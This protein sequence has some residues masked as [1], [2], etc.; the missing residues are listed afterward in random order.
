M[1]DEVRRDDVQ[2]ALAAIGEPTRFRILELLAA[3]PYTVG[4]VAEAIGA[5]Q[6]QTTKHLQVLAAA[7]VVRV[8]KLGRRRVAR[9]DRTALARLGTYFARLAE[10]DPDDAV[11]DAYE[12]AIGAEVAGAGRRVLRFSRTVPASA[13]AVWAAWTDPARAV[14]WWAPRHF[15]VGAFEIAPTALAPIRVVLREGDAAEYESRGRVEEAEPG[16]R[17]V[18]TLAPVDPA[19]TPLFSAR[20]TLTIHGGRQTTVDLV[21]EVSDVRPETAP[22]VAGLE[23]GWVQLLDA[24]DA[25]LRS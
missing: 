21:I 25:F 20:H 23:P 17:L 6:P 2:R 10:S 18:F 15:T 24:L 19:G 4:E 3:R 12:N 9:L 8:H 11:L 14:R 16:R 13:E 22:A 7:G 1:T 5:L